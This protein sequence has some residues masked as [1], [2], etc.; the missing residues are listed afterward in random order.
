M[1]AANTG[2]TQKG[3]H[4]LNLLPADDPVPGK[5]ILQSPNL[6]RILLISK[7]HSENTQGPSGMVLGLK[8]TL[9]LSSFEALEKSQLGLSFTKEGKS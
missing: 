9:N 6:G 5:P 8:Y 4:L 3:L 1:L 2:Q 7:I